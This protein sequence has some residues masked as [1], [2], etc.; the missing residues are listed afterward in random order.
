MPEQ[1]IDPF[2]ITA[3]SDN[4]ITENGKEIINFTTLN[5][6]YNIHLSREDTQLVFCTDTSFRYLCKLKFFNN[7]NIEVYQI[8]LSEV[9]IYVLLDGLN[10]V[11]TDFSGGN[12]SFPPFSISLPLFNNGSNKYNINI[13]IIGDIYRLSIIEYNI[14]SQTHTTRISIDF[15]KEYLIRF[16]NILYY[17]FIVDLNITIDDPKILQKFV[18]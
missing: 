6:D 5:K 8:I 16:A 10:L 14:L 4:I 3:F 11:V 18:Q 9:D 7:L 17:T 15:N 13:N 12:I 2:G 1:F